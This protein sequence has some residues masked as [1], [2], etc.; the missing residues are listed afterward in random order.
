MF[1]ECSDWP[2]SKFLEERAKRPS[3][4]PLGCIQI[5]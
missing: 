5:V 4:F 1:P 3:S 2:R